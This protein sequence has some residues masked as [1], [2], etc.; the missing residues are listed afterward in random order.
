VFHEQEF[1]SYISAFEKDADTDALMAVTSFIDDESPLFVA[2]DDALRVTGFYDANYAGAPFV[3]GGIY[4]FGSR[5]KQVVE[6]AMALN[7]SRMRNFQRMLIEEGLKVSAFPFSK[8]VDIDHVKD[9]ETA[10]LFLMEDASLENGL[11][12]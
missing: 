8:I 5:V 10:R 7:I 12:K 11:I 9:I 4:C 6:K 2:T 1:S 3:S